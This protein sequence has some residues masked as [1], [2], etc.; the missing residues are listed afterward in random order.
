MRGLLGAVLLVLLGIPTIAAEG[1]TVPT[2]PDPPTNCAAAVQTD[3]S[4]LVTWAPPANNGG[5]PLK[6]YALQIKGQGVTVHTPSGSDTSY[7][8]TGPYAVGDTMRVRAVNSVGFSAWCES[9]I[10]DASPPP[11]PPPPPPSRPWLPYTADAWMLQ[12]TDGLT[13]NAAKTSAMRAYITANDPH[14]EPNLQGLGGNAWGVSYAMGQCS[15]PVWRFTTAANGPSQW[16]MLESV[17]FHAPDTLGDDLRAAKANGGTDLP[18]EVQDR[19]TGITV[20]AGQVSYPVAST[21][22]VLQVGTVYGAFEHDSNGLDRRATGSDSTVNERSRGVIPDSMTIRADQVQWAIDNNSDLGQRLEI[23]W[24][25][26]DSSAGKISPPMAGFENGQSGW[27]AEGQLL[28]IDKSI[29]LRARAATVGASPAALAIAL[30]MQHYG[31]YI[32][33]NAGGGGTSLK[34]EQSH[35]Q[36]DGMGL[37]QRGL[38]G[39]VR[40]QDMVAY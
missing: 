27:G 37:S 24:W 17:G 4:V 36:W 21:D 40:W 32:G 20:W 39:L 1:A 18:I 34:L 13:V 15:D 19:C 3:R 26:T 38:A 28:G 30:T 25:E 22:R 10:S 12:T 11:P 35:G 16:Q 14:G 23:F 6:W 29:D 8:W 31:V 33:D 9:A 7:T 5:A 2:V